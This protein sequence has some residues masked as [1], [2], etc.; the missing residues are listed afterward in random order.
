MAVLGV[1]HVFIGKTPE[2]TRDANLKAL[3]TTF[4]FI[5][6]NMNNVHS[7][8]IPEDLLESTPLGRARCWV[9]AVLKLVIQRSADSGEAD[10][11][12]LWQKTGQKGV[13]AVLPQH[14]LRPR[15]Q[16]PAGSAICLHIR[17]T[18]T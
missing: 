16:L 6:K 18:L 13:L 3:E 12:G 4:R 15:S 2:Q 9:H 14:S 1:D 8:Y 5:D 11:E 7:R 17:F 10:A